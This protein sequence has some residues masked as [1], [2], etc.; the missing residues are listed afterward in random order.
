MRQITATRGRKRNINKRTPKWQINPGEAPSLFF[1][2]ISIPF[3]SHV[4]DLSK[5]NAATGFPLR[6]REMKCS[7]RSF[8]FPP[9]SFYFIFLNLCPSINTFFSRRL[10]FFYFL[11]FYSAKQLSRRKNETCV[12]FFRFIP[13]QVQEE[14]G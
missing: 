13:G 9:A 3:S 5:I 11:F 6:V 12:V 2:F 14:V 10:A 4:R 7:Q 1:G 8:S